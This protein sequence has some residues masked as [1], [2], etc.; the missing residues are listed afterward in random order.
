MISKCCLLLI[1]M[2]SP[3][4]FAAEKHCYDTAKTQGELRSC[5]DHEAE[6]ADKRLNDVYQLIL[7]EYSTDPAFIAKLESAQRAW[8][9]FRDAEL[10]AVYPHQDKLASYGSVWPMCGLHERT[11]LTEERTT[12]LRRWVK[13]IPEGDVCAGSIKFEDA[14]KTSKEP[15]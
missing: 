10:Q 8:L 13:G 12:Q 15:K 5:A 14:A 11:R 1:L 7:K 9:S 2:T 6:A 4:T 3:A